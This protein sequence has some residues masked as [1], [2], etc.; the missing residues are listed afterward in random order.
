MPLPFILAGVVVV[1][2]ILARKAV[3]NTGESFVDNVFR[4]AVTP[5]RGSV[6]YCD[7][8]FGN[9][10]HSGIYVGRNLIVQLGRSGDIEYVSPREFIEGT[11]AISIY[12][13]CIDESAVGYERVADRAEASVG[14][15][16]DYSFLTNNCHIFCSECLTGQSNSDTF[17][18]MLKHT[19][20]QMMGVNT[21]RVWD[22]GNDDL[23]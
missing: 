21:W 9:M 5:V 18:W 19:V 12:V 6:L 20:E 2:G 8:A 16:R 14:S 17:R 13:S 10:D 11:T 23:F 15:T 1:A 3:V 7:M 4:D 22:I